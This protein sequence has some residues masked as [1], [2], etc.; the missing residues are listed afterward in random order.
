[1][2]YQ[3][4]ARL[5]KV[6]P[7]RNNIYIGKGGLRIPQALLLISLF[8]GTRYDAIEQYDNDSFIVDSSIFVFNLL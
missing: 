4:H 3:C 5:V 8:D 7:P 6:Q 2:L 1:M